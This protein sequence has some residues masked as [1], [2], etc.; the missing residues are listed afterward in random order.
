[1]WTRQ[2]YSATLAGLVLTLGVR[3]AVAASGHYVPLHSGNVTGTYTIDPQHTNVLFTIGHVGITRFT[4]RFD[5]ISGTYTLNSQEPKKDQA[6]IVIQTSSIDTGFAL[7]DKDLRSA[8]FFDAKKYPVITFSSTRYV[9]TGPKTGRLY[10]RL[11]L[12]GVSKPVTFQ[13]RE[14]GAGAVTY[15]PKPWGGYLSGFV[16]TTVIHRSQFG[17]DAYLPEGLSNAIRV[18]VEV[19]GVKNP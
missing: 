10:G 19:E 1:M 8:E 2:K 17:M 18:K 11:T 4:G 13:V 3:A 9:S 14:I 5:K 7:R 16:A 12:H 15:L 6:H